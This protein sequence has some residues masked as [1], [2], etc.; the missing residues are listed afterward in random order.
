MCVKGVCTGI[1]CKIY[2]L[3]DTGRGSYP[4]THKIMFYLSLFFIPYIL[5]HGRFHSSATILFRFRRSVGANLCF[6]KTV[7][8]KEI[9]LFTPCWRIWG[10]GSENIFVLTIA[11]PNN[12]WFSK[13]KIWNTRWFSR[14]QVIISRHTVYLVTSY[15]VHRSIML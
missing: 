12:L 4:I 14:K 9:E 6:V 7:A 10:L 3:P 15:L 11:S 13:V 1:I 5:R 8:Y 2:S